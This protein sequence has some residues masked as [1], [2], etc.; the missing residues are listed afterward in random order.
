MPA[1]DNNSRPF[2]LGEFPAPDP[3]AWRTEV[4]RLLKGAPFEKAM[5]TRTLEGITL[6]PMPTARETADLPW[7]H[8]APGQTPFQRGSRQGGYHE[9]PW[10]IAQEIRLPLPTEVNTALRH[11]LARG[12]TAVNLVL[13]PAAGPHDLK[14]CLSGV[15]LQ[16]VPVM[17]D[18]GGAARP[19]AAGLEAL[20]DSAGVDRDRVRA[21]LGCDPV[22]GLAQDGVLPQ[23]AAELYNQLA[24]LTRWA[25]DAPLVRTLPVR[26]TVWHDGGADH[27]LSL[28]LTMAGAAHVLQEMDGRGIQPAD[29]VRRIHFHVCVDADFFMSLTKLRALRLL[30]SRMQS[31]AG[32]DPR[33]AWI[34]AR[35]SRRMAS[36]L[37]PYPNLLRGTTA[38]MSAVLGGIDSL[39]VEPFTTAAGQPGELARRLARN[40]Q[41]ILAHECHLDHVADPAGGAW[42]PESLTAD[43]AARAWEH[44]REVEQAG[45]ILSALGAGLVQ[46][47]IAAAAAERRRRL[48]I[49]QDAM[50]GVNRYCDPGTALEETAAAPAQTRPEAS[51]C[52]PVPVRRDAEPFEA[53]RRRVLTGGE[54]P[55]TRI[56]CVCLGDPAGYMPRLDFVRRFFQAGG[57]RVVAEGFVDSADGAAAIAGQADAA[58]VIIVG[59]DETYAEQAAAVAGLLKKMHPQPRV[60]LAGRPAD[61]EEEWLFAGVDEF[62]HARSDM[63][64]VLART[65]GNLEVAP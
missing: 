3:E 11:D 19:V 18:A 10:L 47:K 56:G 38:A 27:A 7:L 34:H 22:A 25:A 60:L 12:L 4:E 26:E 32:L 42:H 59:L 65:A 61:R 62:L 57:F 35:T 63:L 52:E 54:R 5:L 20:W 45:G 1:T 9:V 31:A 37:E 50:V 2:S 33:A 8:A 30:W 29:A 6:D 13:D 40:V 16:A 15:G 48:A 43:L 41:L 39:H 64:D 58:T 55:A 51:T 17:I 21:Y 28:G 44:L 23:P 49:G 14:T 46:E 24:E 53:I 36:V